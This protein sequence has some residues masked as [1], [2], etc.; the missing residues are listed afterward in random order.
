MD[1][2]N[3]PKSFLKKSQ[4]FRTPFSPEKEI[5]LWVDRIGESV[6]ERQTPQELREL[7][8][9]GAV[10]VERGSGY[11]ITT[12]AGK[13]RVSSGDVLML[14][15]F[16]AHCYYPQESW[17]RKWIVWSGTEAAVLERLGYVKTGRPVVRDADGVFLKTYNK[18]VPLIR[19]E[20][21]GAVLERKVLLLDLLRTLYAN[22]KEGGGGVKRD[23]AMANAVAFITKNY[24]EDIPVA[25]LAAEAHLSE[26]HFRRLFKAYTGRSPSR[27][28][29]FVRTARAKELLSEGRPIKE[30]APL[31]GYEDMFYFMK[32]FKKI[33]GVPPGRF[34]EM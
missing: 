30:V 27:F 28:I 14:F 5:G 8:L 31:V 10:Y 15:P 3:I 12:S 25:D 1:K 4:R 26:A 32:V 6:A 34:Q 11:F 22:R 18:L 33:T 23:E 2:T 29:A 24:R 20:D 19:R 21:A 17:D 7:G 16:E 9:Y 13:Q